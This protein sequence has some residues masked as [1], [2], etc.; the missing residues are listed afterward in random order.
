MNTCLYA[1]D[2]DDYACKVYEQ[3]WPD[4]TLQKEDIRNVTAEDVCRRGVPDLICGGFPC[5]DVSYAGLGAGIE[6]ARSGL[7]SEMFRLV[8]EV[9]PRYVVVENVPGLLGRGLGKVLAD[10]A[11]VGYDAEWE[12]LP[13]CAF[14]ASHIRERIF[15]VANSDGYGLQD[16]SGV[17]PHKSTAKRNLQPYQRGEQ[18]PD[19]LVSFVANRRNVFSKR[20][21][22]V[23]WVAE[24]DIPRM[25]NGIPN[26][27]HRIKALGNA[28]VPQVAQFVGECVMAHNGGEF[29]FAECFCGIGG[30][31]LG[32]EWASGR[33]LGQ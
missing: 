11:S 12:V 21:A 3:H 19:R 27:L 20:I 14:G 18:S 7:W 16:S 9:R 6:G 30:F 17:K 2:I 22:D 1:N 13:A 10:L 26:Q 29:T 24:P 15:M 5:Q 33:E 25:A 31:R 28:I 4:G 32:F 8:C 23:Q